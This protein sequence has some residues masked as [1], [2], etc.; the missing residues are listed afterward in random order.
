VTREQELNP[1]KRYGF[2]FF[3]TGPARIAGVDMNI[4]GEGKMG[5]WIK[6]ILVFN[7]AYTNPKVLDTGFVFTETD[8][9]AYTYMN[10]SS[11][12]TGFIMK[13]RI[14]H[15]LKADLDFKIYNMFTIGFSSQFYSLMK[16][17]DKF[18]YELDRYSSIAPRNVRNSNYPFPFD[19]LETYRQNHNKGTWVFAMRIGVE[20]LNLKFSVI[21]NNLFNKEYSLRPMCPEPPRMTTFQIIYKF[22]EGEPFFSKRKINT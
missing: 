19:G 4:G 11:D 16:N 1:L 2:K 9:K 3:N 13:Y 22:T 21:A 10:T 5:K 18:F 7:Y 6:Y 8:T 12:T 14:E 17:V 15:I 20:V